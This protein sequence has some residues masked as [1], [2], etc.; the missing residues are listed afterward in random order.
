MG[1][2]FHGSLIIRILK[3]LKKIKGS[4]LTL[5]GITSLYLASL[6]AYYAHVVKLVNTPVL[7]T[8]TVAGLWVRV[9]P[10]APYD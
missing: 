10:W 6:N 2:I 1:L 8:G 4:G 9:P 5:A 7:E 3:Q